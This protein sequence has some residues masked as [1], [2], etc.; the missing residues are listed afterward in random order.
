MTPNYTAIAANGRPTRVLVVDDDRTSREFLCRALQKKGYAVTTAD[1]VTAGRSL[2]SGPGVA[3]FETV[4]TDYQMPEQTGLDLLDWLRQQDGTLTG[5]VLTGE[6]EKNIVAESLRAGAAD[7]L[8]KPVNLPHLFE[9]LVKA[10]NVTRRRRQLAATESAV[11]NLGRAQRELFNTSK[12]KVSCGEASVDVCFH[13]KL[14]AGGDFF[15]HFQPVPDKLCCLMTDVSGHDLE[16]AFVSAYF[17]G[18]VHGMEQCHAP[19][20]A[21]FQ[22]FNSFLVK[23]W[24]HSPQ[25]RLHAKNSETSVATL[26]VTIDFL[27]QTIDVLA[28]GTPAPVLVSADGR[29]GALGQSGGVPLGWFPDWH[30]EVTTHSITCGGTILMW[31][32]GLEE[33]ANKFDVHPLCA[34]HVLEQTRSDGSGNQL[35]D[36]AEDDVLLTSVRLPNNPAAAGFYRPLLLDEYHGAQAGEIDRLVDRWQRHLLLAQPELSEEHLHD[37][38]LATREA[39]LNA[40][41]HGCG[42]DASKKIRFQISRLAANNSFK[43]WIEDPGCGHRF[44]FLSHEQA[45]MEMTLAEHRGLIFMVNLADA[46]SFERNGATVILEFECTPPR[47]MKSD[48]SI[49]IIAWSGDLTSTNAAGLR[50]RLQNILEPAAGQDLGWQIL[51][52]ELNS[53]RMVDSVGLNLVV[54][55]LRAVQKSSRKMQVTYTNPNVLRTFQFTRLDQFIELI[56][57]EA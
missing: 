32:D 6:S 24:N 27:K 21:I 26:S 2:L 43:I 57:V 25:F 45:A 47:P 19:A 39:V 44:D 42:G 56:K 51:R 14:E 48:L 15:T 1:G 17:Q 28:C 29:A 33:L 8:E 55:I 53:T 54:S 18:M 4:V 11:K 10:V 35:L 50:A 36:Q 7:F 40:M 23:E 22:F 31:T 37:I 16:A 13:P 9:A 34:A 5:I 12:V 3:S 30:P 46:V 52:L 38:V 49:H 41:N 20:S